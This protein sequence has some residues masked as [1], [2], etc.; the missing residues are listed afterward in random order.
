MAILTGSDFA[1]EI[2]L[3]KSSDKSAVDVTGFDLQ[4]CIKARRGDV[5]VLLLLS[6][7]SG[8]AVSDATNGRL[9]LSLSAEQTTAIGAGP[10]VWGLFRVDGGRRLALATGKMTV[11]QGV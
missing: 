6:I 7:G 11:R 8:L 5:R 1:R 3:Q 9:T 10:R 2:R 4:L